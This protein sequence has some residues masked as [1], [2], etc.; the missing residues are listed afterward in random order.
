[1][2]IYFL[3]LGMLL[4]GALL[5]IV[6]KEQWKFKVC[7]IFSFLSA[8]TMM[9][10]AVA[11]LIKGIPLIK[12]VELS[13]ITG[14]VDFIIDP[15]TAFFL[16]VISIMSFL[17]VLYA[18][19]YMKPYLNKGMNVSSHC[20]FLMMLIAS[21]TM[22]VTVQNALFFLIV[23]EIMSLSS[24]FLVIFEGEKK[25]VL[26]AG[27][28]YLVYMHLSVIFIMAAFIL[29]NIKTSSLN[30]GAY[31][32]Y[33]HNDAS[34]AN[35]IFLLAFVGFGIKAGFVPFH[36]W[37][38]D[39]HP[40]AP[41]H[42]SGIMSGVMIKTGI[43]GILRFLLFVGT[44]SKMI[45]YTVLT[46]AVIS[47]LYGVLYAVTQQDLKRLLA[48][49]SIENIAIIGIGIGVGM[50]GLTYGNPYVAV[51]G[52]AGGILH[53]LNHSIFKELMF[54][55]AGSVYLKTHTRNMELL[56][57]LMKKMPYTG[58]LFI[59]GSIAIC[60]LPPFNGFIGE[61]L[62]YA[63]MI[64]GIPASEISLFLV[65]ILS[66]A[67]LGMVGT[68][69]MLCFTKAAGI[70]FLG[71]PRTECV[72]HVN[73]DVPRVMLIPMVILAFLAFFIGMFPQYFI[74]IVMWPVSMLVNVDK[75]A[76]N[77]ALDEVFKNTFGLILSDF[78]WFFLIFFAVV[79]VM[80]IV[81]LI[82]NRKARISNI[83]GCGYN[84]LNNHVQ[85]TGSSYANLFIS[86]L[87]PLFK[88][89]SHIKKPK[90]LFP[91]EAYYEL[92]IED[93]EEAYIVKPLVMW[94]EK[95][96]T[97]FERIQNGNI[98]QYILFGLIFLILAIIGMIYFGG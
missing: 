28:K 45:S 71:N 20:F 70:T 50:L 9:L 58:L 92:E 42:V 4:I 31:A 21:M 3:A 44:P 94:D 62:I 18:N 73:E 83:W 37:L 24:F 32:Y 96:L 46:I 90:E 95:F 26:K 40:A 7:S 34:M 48:Y 82:V 19:G 98:Q 25:E 2:E 84:R 91:K 69:A 66:I 10:P 36:N 23:W 41:S 64:M 15:L 53:I 11:V 89:V 43:Y 87:K 63:G 80:F 22:V 77:P 79:A 13:P 59:V 75:Y 14:N 35:L 76:A 93:I 5:S 67:A 27:I 33:L 16:I 78:S 12:T 86:T 51:L 54:F 39:A 55:A 81:K 49:S 88:R 85:Y 52:F 65:L 8:L 29:L 68:M 74:S 61:F 47:A 56:G 57:G 38:P 97:K 60:G 30:F 6:V 1:M 72:E 17:G